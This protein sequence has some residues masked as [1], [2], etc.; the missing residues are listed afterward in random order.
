MRYHLSIPCILILQIFLLSQTEA[1]LRIPIKKYPI[2]DEFHMINLISLKTHLH[3]PK[4]P[5]VN[6]KNIQ[7]NINMRIGSNNQDFLL[8][9]DTGSTIIWVASS[10]YLGEPF[11]NRFFNCSLSH[12][13][14]LTNQEISL[15]YSDLSQVEGLMISDTI[16]FSME[17]Q[18]K[19]QNI[20]M[21]SSSNNLAYFYGDGLIGFGLTRDTTTSSFIDNA[22]QQGLITERV[23]SMYLSKIDNKVGSE[24]ILGGFDRN[25]M[26]GD[27]ND[28]NYF[29]RTSN[30]EYMIHCDSLHIGSKTIKLAINSGL[31]DSGTVNIIAPKS[32]FLKVSSAFKSIR[33]KC[34]FH[35]AEGSNDTGFIVCNC[36]KKLISSFPN[37]SFNF[38]NENGK[39]INFEFVPEEY[40]YYSDG[41]CT[42]LIQYIEGNDVWIFGSLFMTKFY[43]IFDIE[44]K[45]IGLVLANHKNIS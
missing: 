22:K 18:V 11:S 17:F 45:K 8:Y 33:R 20:L 30:E 34:F 39:L 10:D 23:F 4:L 6:Y 12:S 13:C 15:Q 35:T 5:L 36:E 40:I 42:I 37:L 31:I 44:R 7:Y 19:N 9:V 28:F 29:D 2:S 21:V 27:S 24:I 1:F 43:T 41:Y 3:T 32:D 26:D 16:G 38:V 25:Y 14:N